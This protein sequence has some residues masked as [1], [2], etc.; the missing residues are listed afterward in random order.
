[1][2]PPRSASDHARIILASIIPNRRDLLDRALR[3]LTP[4][5]FEDQ[6]LKNLFL[7]LERY[8]EVTN[9][10][11]T[12]AALA[13]ILASS[14]RDPG[15]A[16]HYQETYALLEAVTPAESEFLWSLEQIR[17]LAAERATGAAITSGMAILNGGLDGEKGQTYRGHA[18]ARAYVLQAFSEI[19][20]SLS[21]QESPEGDIRGEGRAFLASYASRKQ[22]RLSGTLRVVQTGVEGI[23]SRIGG[24]EPGELNLVVG[25]TNS[26]K[27][28][29]CVQLA[30]HAAVAQGLHVVYATTETLRPQVTRKIISRHSRLEVFGLPEGLN[31]RDLKAGTLSPELE[32][33]LQ[34]VVED[35]TRNPAYG[36]L[37]VIQ[38]PRGAGVPALETRLVRLARERDLGLVILD[39]AQLLSSSR[40]YDSLREELGDVVK[41]AKAVATTLQDG[42]GVPLIS[43][44]QTNRRSYEEAQ[45]LGYYTTLALSETAE[46]ANTPDVIL[47]S[48]EP[49]ENDSRY[50]QLKVQILKNRDGETSGVFD[51]SVD[52]AT[53]RFSSPRPGG[54]GDELDLLGG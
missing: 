28:S 52:Y 5:L 2:T 39:Y 46:A 19:D 47:S 30:W 7:L 15:T 14:G 10:V 22:A 21:L 12:S 17:D 16:A 43:P 49:Q 27:T 4:D 31:S 24:F 45:R 36:S 6:V 38:L 8:A 13:D 1:L 41:S 26:G 25:Y 35:F 20:R 11:M 42:R 50:A 23:D 37:N 48:L 40:R 44:W 9:S 53:S 32:P 54:T 33:K 29:L 3:D 18:D 51:V 34:E